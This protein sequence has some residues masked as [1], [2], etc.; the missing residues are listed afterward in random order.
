MFLYIP[1]TNFLL[2]SQKNY[3]MD[4]ALYVQHIREHYPSEILEIYEFLVAQMEQNQVEFSQ[5]SDDGRLNSAVDENTIVDGLFQAFPDNIEKPK[6]RHWFDV[7]F[8]IKSRL[9]FNIKVSTGKTD[10]AMNKKAVVYSLTG[11][12]DNAIKN[13]MTYNDMASFVID[14]LNEV[15]N[16]YKEYYYMYIDKLDGTII[17][18]SLLDIQ[19]LVSNPCNILQIN[20]AKE[21]KV[22]H[23]FNDANVHSAKK[24]IFDVIGKSL[25]QMVESCSQFLNQD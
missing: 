23:V 18:K 15:R 21:K 16:P 4:K 7:S 6:K 2:T 8:K 9:V 20:W 1:F 25:K 5:A 12:E 17:I 10:N 13:N 19:N 11:L 22:A 3:K 14:N 24:R